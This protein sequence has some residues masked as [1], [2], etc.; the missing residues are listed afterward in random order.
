MIHLSLSVPAEMPLPSQVLA[1]DRPMYEAMRAA[2]KYFGGRNPEDLDKVA[3]LDTCVTVVDAK[4]F[5]GDVATCDSLLERYKDKV[6]GILS[7]QELLLVHN[8]LG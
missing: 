7:G 1:D 6:R 5:S 2:S 4:A 8:V 3:R